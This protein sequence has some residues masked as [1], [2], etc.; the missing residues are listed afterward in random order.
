MLCLFYFFWK[1]IS[2][3]KNAQKRGPIQL[4]QEAISCA[5]SGLAPDRYCEALVATV[6]KPDI[7]RYE[8]TTCFFL[9]PVLYFFVEFIFQIGAGVHELGHMAFCVRCPPFRNDPI[10]HCAARF[11]EFSMVLNSGRSQSLSLT[12]IS[13]KSLAQ[14]VRSNEWVSRDSVTSDGR[15]SCS[16]LRLRADVIRGWR[17]FRF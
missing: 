11:I 14:V 3:Q 4:D 8:R 2:N 5:M 6:F 15:I 13:G 7:K 1:L 16:L 12:T 10:S 17:N 9:R